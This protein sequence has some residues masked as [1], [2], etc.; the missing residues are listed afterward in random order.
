MKMRNDKRK[1]LIINENGE[2]IIIINMEK[3]CKENNF[4][5]TSIFTNY[6]NKD[7]FYKGLKFKRI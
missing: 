5:Y 6:L 4:S 1:Y 3:Y 7:M 2:E